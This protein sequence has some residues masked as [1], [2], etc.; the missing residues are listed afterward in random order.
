MPAIGAG[1]PT[2]TAAEDPGVSGNSDGLVR[3][4][5]D[6]TVA[7][8]AYRDDPA[9][10]G[11]D[12]LHVR[13]D[14]VECPVPGGQHHNRHVLIDQG[15]GTVA[16]SRA[17][18]YPFRVNVADLLHLQGALE[19]QRE[20]GIPRPRYSMCPESRMASASSRICPSLP[21]YF[22]HLGRYPGKGFGHV[23]EKRMRTGPC[24]RPGGGASN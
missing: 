1:E 16:S 22:L 12:F 8:G 5:G 11:P 13:D 6:F 19:R 4:A 17:A 14:L 24:A 23:L 21:Q 3:Q 15:N 10:S 7:V 18:G 9:L 2:A 20:T